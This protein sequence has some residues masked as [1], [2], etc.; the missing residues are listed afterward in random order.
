M[1]ESWER[2]STKYNRLLHPNIRTT[3]SQLVYGIDNSVLAIASTLIIL[4]V[5]FLIMAVRKSREA[6]REPEPQAAGQALPHPRRI[7]DEQYH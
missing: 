6:L 3:M 5:Y 2:F 4:L 7:G 1:L